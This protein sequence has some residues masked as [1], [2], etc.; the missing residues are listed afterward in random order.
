MTSTISLFKLIMV[1]VRLQAMSQVQMTFMD[2]LIMKV[3]VKIF[4]V[5]FQMH[6][7]HEHVYVPRPWFGY[8]K[9]W[10][11]FDILCTLHMLGWSAC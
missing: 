9:W 4:Q 11:V 5:N 8:C 2:L 6:N 1:R 3:R 10:C 7:A